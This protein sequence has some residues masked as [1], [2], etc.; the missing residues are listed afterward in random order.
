M[1]HKNICAPR[2]RQVRNFCSRLVFFVI[3]FVFLST[4]KVRVRDSI[5][6]WLELSRAVDQKQH[7]KLIAANTE[8]DKSNYFMTK[9]RLGNRLRQNKRFNTMNLVNKR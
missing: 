5:I 8:H 1:R 2:K 4:S 3:V 9:P 6:K 7:L